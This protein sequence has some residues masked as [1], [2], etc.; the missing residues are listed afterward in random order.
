MVPHSLEEGHD[1]RAARADFL[2]RRGR[3]ADH[4]PLGSLR[5]L[6]SLALRADLSGASRGHDDEAADDVDVATAEGHQLADAVLKRSAQPSA[7]LLL[8]KRPE[9]RLGGDVLDQ[10]PVCGR[11]VAPHPLEEGT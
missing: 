1:A 5:S 3:S 8:D 7:V 2:Q 11:H 9:G 6:R 10:P 4:A